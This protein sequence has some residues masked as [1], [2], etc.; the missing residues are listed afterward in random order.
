MDISPPAAARLAAIG[1]EE[2]VARPRL[3]GTELAV[4]R[5][6]AGPPVLCLHALGHGGGDFAPLAE[7]LSNRFEF[8]A[9]DWPGQGRSPCDGGPAR[10]GRYADLVLAA[11]DALGLE[12]PIVI[13]NSIGGAAALIA[14]ARATDRFAGLVLCNP[15]GL[16]PLDP[17]SRFVIA[18]MAAMFSAGAAG[19]AWF[20]AAFAAYYRYLVLPAPAARAQRARIIAAG[21]DLA[22]LLADGW[23]GFA[24]TDADLTDLT[25]RISVP[26]WLA[27]ARGD[28]FVSWARAKAAASRLPCHRLT[29]FP[30][31]HAAFLEAPDAFAA[32]FLA[33]ADELRPSAVAARLG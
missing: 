27:W 8:I 13:G 4:K 28:Q 31:G 7:R 25:A 21:R 22:P 32:G 18:R 9:L 3:S 1:A 33:Y 14:A 6:G 24:E 29:L 23:R 19:A 5:W 30:G 15:G 16:S 10:A 2:P 26:V 11:C 17:L 20:P 12:R